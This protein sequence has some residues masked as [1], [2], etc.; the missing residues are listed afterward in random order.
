MGSCSFLGKRDRAVPKLP[1]FDMTSDYLWPEMHPIIFTLLLVFHTTGLSKSS[2]CTA[3]HQ[4]PPSRLGRRVCALLRAQLILKLFE[5]HTHPVTSLVDIPSFTFD[6]S[7]SI[8]LLDDCS[9]LTRRCKAPSVSD[10]EIG[11]NGRAVVL[12]R[13]RTTT[14]KHCWTFNTISYRANPGLHEE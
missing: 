3:C 8:R 2:D 12:E 6:N 11:A 10:S 9:C 7:K 5:L 14:H 1:T 4:A 13:I